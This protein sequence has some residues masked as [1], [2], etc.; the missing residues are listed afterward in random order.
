MK[1]LL[2]IIAAMCFTLSAAAGLHRFIADEIIKECRAEITEDTPG[3]INIIRAS[4]PQGYTESMVH[5]KV[6]RVFNTQFAIF[7][8]YSELTGRTVNIKQSRRTWR[9]G[10]GIQLIADVDGRTMLIGYNNETNE[11]IIIW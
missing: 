10:E 3:D 11:L 6:N 8:K 1:K 7:E 9:K 4:L 5:N 2:F